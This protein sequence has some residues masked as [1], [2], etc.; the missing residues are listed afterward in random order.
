MFQPF[1]C[2]GVGKLYHELLRI[3]P[4]QISTAAQQCPA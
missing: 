2:K 3:P 4:L 1:A